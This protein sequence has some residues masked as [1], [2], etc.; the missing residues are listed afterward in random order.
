V[1]AAIVGVTVAS[2]VADK[3]LISERDAI[4]VALGLTDTDWLG[5]PEALTEP[6][7]DEEYVC[8][9]EML[10]YSD[11]DTDTDGDIELDGDAVLDL[12]LNAEAELVRSAE[13]LREI[14]DDG[15]TVFRAVA[16]RVLLLDLVTDT[17]AV[18]ERDTIAVP[19]CAI[20]L[21]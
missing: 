9:F 13:E 6:I 14:D 21:V 19:V 3:E 18:D 15:V 8:T 10:E 4:V 20:D 2:G 1:E 17:L 12:L 5:D 11:P 16:V 7:S